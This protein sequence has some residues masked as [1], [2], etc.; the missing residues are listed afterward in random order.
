[1]CL[2]VVQ[3]IGAQPIKTHPHV[4]VD[5]AAD[6]WVDC[7]LDNT[8]CS[9]NIPLFAIHPGASD[10]SKQWPPDLFAKLVDTVQ[11]K[12]RVRWILIGS[13]DC[14]LTATKLSEMCQQSLLDMTGQTSLVQFLSL[15]KRCQLLVSNDSGPVHLA[16][17]LGTPVVSIFTRNQPGINAC[18]WRPLS[19]Y[20]T[21]VSVPETQGMNFSKAGTASDDYRRQIT[22]EQVTRAI[23]R[24]FKLC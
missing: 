7:F 17:A 8:L 15:L 4:P 10:P 11:K 23:D 18:R 6:K 14:A 13:A 20:S 12:G 22:V 24:I 1:L 9:Q 21:F 5:S 3:H 16:D 19:A 2:D